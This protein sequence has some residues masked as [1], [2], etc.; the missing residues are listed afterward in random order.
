MAKAK[1]LGLAGRVKAKEGLQAR[2]TS[3]LNK[4]SPEVAEELLT[5]IKSWIANQTVPRTVFIQ[6]VQ[7]AGREHGDTLLASFSDGK[8]VTI[9]K[10]LRDG[11]L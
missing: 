2:K 6:V 7:D 5:E 4:L 10:Y 11:V 1:G 9:E 3:F 8:L